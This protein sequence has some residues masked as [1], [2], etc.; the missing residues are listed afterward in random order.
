MKKLLL[1]SGI[2]LLL[3]GCQKQ[4]QDEQLAD[5][6]NGYEKFYKSGEMVKTLIAGQNIDVGTVTYGI[7]F[8]AN[9]YV[10]YQTSG[11]WVM[12]ETHM[13]AG[14]WAD[15]P[16]NKPGNPKVGQFPYSG[17]HGAGVTTVT[18]TIPLENLPPC[19]DPGF[20]VATH[21][22]VKNLS[23][24]QNETAWG[25]WDNEFCDRRWGGYSIYY[26]NEPPVAHTLLYGSAY[27]NGLLNIYVINATNG[28][29]D[30]VLSEDIGTYPTD[31]YDGIAWDP[32]S[33]YLFFTT[34]SEG[35]V[36]E[37]MINTMDENTIS[38][39]AGTLN[40]VAQSAT[41][42]DGK[43]YYINEADN[44]INAVIFS[45]DWSIGSETVVSTI[46]S[47][48]VVNDLAIS[49]DGSTIYMVGVYQ[50]NT[51][52]ISLD[53][54]TDTYSTLNINLAGDTQIAYG[55]DDQLYT[56]STIGTGSLV[57]SL[58][59]TTG[60]SNQISDQDIGGGGVIISDLGR[61][62]IQ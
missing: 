14:V 46:P 40:G 45:S 3:I 16:K 25:N 6:W 35:V 23:N 56:V 48:I 28:E 53:M 27:D 26:Y 9:F 36:S 4:Q 1:L 30:L 58:D 31:T 8:N 60:T 15:L 62:P 22:V 51:Q 21:A 7:D 50:T 13:F 19:E 12:L 11:S 59:P 10:T 2:V 37:L 29:S 61:G 5:K 55:S 47:N 33:N 41:F 18:Y 52:L 42:Y 43:F 38:F 49:P 39:S 17:S 57:S 34:Y 20:I 54:S 44:T 32:V 24:G